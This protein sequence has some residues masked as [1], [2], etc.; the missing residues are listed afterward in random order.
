MAVNKSFALGEHYE[1]FIAHQVSLG[2]FQNAS[3]VVR[4]GLRMLEDYELRIKELRNRIEEGDLALQEGRYQEYE[5]ANDL[6]NSVIGN[7]T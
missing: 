4:A 2:R 7:S 5:S 6:L 3:E 1:N